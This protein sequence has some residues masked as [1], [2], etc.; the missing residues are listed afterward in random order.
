MKKIYLLSILLAASCAWMTTTL[1]GA[2]TK[3]G[4]VTVPIF[5]D[6]KPPLEELPSPWTQALASLGRC[7][8]WTVKRPFIHFGRFWNGHLM[9]NPEFRAEFYRDGLILGGITMAYLLYLMYNAKYWQ[10][11]AKPL[12][13]IPF[14]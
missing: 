3:A 8:L 12:Q 6:P 14:I 1:P 5:I 11:R 10:K 2:L 9:A 7:T 13:E 4:T